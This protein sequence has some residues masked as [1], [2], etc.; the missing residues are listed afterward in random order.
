MYEL[1]DRNLPDY[2][3]LCCN[4]AETI[5][6]SKKHSSKER[7][8]TK[9]NDKIVDLYIYSLEDV[10]ILTGVSQWM[11]RSWA[12]KTLRAIRKKNIWY[13]HKEDVSNLLKEM[14]IVGSTK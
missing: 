1:D 10:V 4:R 2:Y 12:N 14:E 9:P 7:Q 11:V 6:T 3:C 8:K 13:Y 5:K